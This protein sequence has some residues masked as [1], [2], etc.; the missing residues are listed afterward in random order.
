MGVEIWRHHLLIA[1]HL[2]HLILAPHLNVAP[3]QKNKLN[4]RLN[5]E[6]E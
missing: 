2:S 4:P 6:P 3:Y 5:P 1:L